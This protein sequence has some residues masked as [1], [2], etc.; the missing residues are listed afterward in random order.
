MNKDLVFLGASDFTL[1]PS[2]VPARLYETP[3]INL[4][5]PVSEVIHFETRVYFF[6]ERREAD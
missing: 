3:R 4:R 6:E 1:G 2:S 5:F